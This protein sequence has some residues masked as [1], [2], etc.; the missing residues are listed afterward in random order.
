M[1]I[2]VRNS[3]GRKFS[4]FPDLCIPNAERHRPRK[5]ARRGTTQKN[6]AMNVPNLT[7][8]PALP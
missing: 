4:L 5:H 1:V 2:S 8:F 6:S 3:D 7:A